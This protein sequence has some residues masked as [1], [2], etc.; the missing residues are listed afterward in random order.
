MPEL[1]CIESALLATGW[2]RQGGT[3]PAFACS[4]SSE[5]QQPLVSSKSPTRPADV[6]RNASAIC[7]EPRRF[8]AGARRLPSPG[9]VIVYECDEAAPGRLSRLLQVRVDPSDA[10]LEFLFNLPFR[11]S[12][13]GADKAQPDTRRYSP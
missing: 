12:V 11:R 1:D 4:P 3:E 2:T 6:P 8:P 13:P 10:S 5:P 7:P 9:T